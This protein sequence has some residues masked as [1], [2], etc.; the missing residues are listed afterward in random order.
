MW[1]I[2][3]ASV[4]ARWLDIAFYGPTGSRSPKL[5]RKDQH[6]YP[7]ILISLY[8]VTY[9]LSFFYRTQQAV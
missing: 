9:R 8:D 1:V 7:V 2:D 3:L 5:V 4:K 6:Q